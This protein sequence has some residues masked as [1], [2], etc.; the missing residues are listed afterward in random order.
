MK[1]YI[2]NMVCPRCIMAVK[3]ILADMNIKAAHIQ[4]GEVSLT[5][6]LDNK[7]LSDFKERLE[8]I[9]FELLDNEEKQL[10]EKIKNIVIHTIRQPM[11]G[12][13]V[14]SDI[15]ADNLRKDYSYLSKLF[16]GTEGV[17]IEHFIIQQKIERVKELLTYNELT[18]SEIAAEMAYSSVAHLS[19]QFK[20]ITGLTPS[21]FKKQGV[22]LRKS[23]DSL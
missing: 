12:H 22:G 4:L 21:R 23:L 13:I 19:A 2:K 1:L 16:S 18:L 11:D 14:F 3:G 6:D 7:R 8:Q 17:T 15:L 10:I 5:G 20:K 9:G